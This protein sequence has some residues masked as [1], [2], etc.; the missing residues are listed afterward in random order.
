MSHC[1]L[2]LCFSGGICLQIV[3]HPHGYYLWGTSLTP[4][5]WEKPLPECPLSAQNSLPA[6]PVSPQ[7]SCLPA[8]LPAIP[9]GRVWWWLGPW[10]VLEV[11]HHV[12]YSGGVSVLNPYK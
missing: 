11:Q 12:V 5:D 9:E 6:A 2:T 10:L 4:Q 3:S 1:S 8:Y 7:M